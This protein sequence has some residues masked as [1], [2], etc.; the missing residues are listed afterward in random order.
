MRLLFGDAHDW[1]EH[2]TH[3]DNAYWMNRVQSLIGKHSTPPDD[4]GHGTTNTEA[5]LVE[6]VTE[7]VKDAPVS[8]GLTGLPLYDENMYAFSILAQIAALW[9]SR[10]HLAKL[11]DPSRPTGNAMQRYHEVYLPWVM[12]IQMLLADISHDPA[13]FPGQRWQNPF[14]PN[15]ESGSFI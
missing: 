1:L 13:Y 2:K 5:V 11:S 14:D 4:T 10:V 12:G 8:G 6:L 7:I 9:Y 15:S 3:K